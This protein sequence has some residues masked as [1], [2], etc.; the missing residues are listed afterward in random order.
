M[1]FYFK[2]PDYTP[3][4]KERIRRL[5]VLREEMRK[6]AGYL[7]KLKAYY[8]DHIAQFLNDWGVTIDVRLVSEGRDPLMPFL[9]FPKQVELVDWI[10]ERW[11]N[12]EPGVVVKARDVGA[13]W[14]AMAAGA[15]MCLFNRNFAVGVG[16]ATEIKL[17]RSGDP[18]T[19]FYKL[20]QFLQHLPPE[21]RG[22]WTLDK[23]SAYMRLS[24][25]ETGSSI[26]GEAGD[27]CGR[28]GRKSIFFVDESA[29]FEHPKLIDA[30]LAATTNCRIDMSS[31]NG[32][33]NSFY[34]KA[35]N[36]A[37][38][39]FDFTWRDDPRK[40]QAWYDKKCAELDP[41]IVAQEINCDWN[42]SIE[43][44]VIPSAWVQ[45]AVGLHERLG[46]TVAGSKRAALDVADR[47]VDKNAMAFTHGVLLV[48]AESWSGKD[49]DIA[50][51]TSKAFRLCDE[52]GYDEFDYDADG[53][54]AGVRGDARVLNEHR[55]QP[56]PDARPRGRPINVGEYRGSGAVIFPERIVPRTNRKNEDFYSNRKA[57][58]WWSAKLRFAESF[59]ASK[60]EPY[61]PDSIIC[62]AR[63]IPELSRLTS[64][65]SQA[66]V[67]ETMT[68]KLQIN[69]TPDDAMS[70]NL[71]DAI[72]MAFAPRKPTMRVSDAALDRF[73]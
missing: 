6:D 22:G 64:E 27:Q 72:I 40:D 36:P 68:G 5:G 28:G 24:F 9:L 73:R 20:R 21:F 51:T 49:S 48:H 41:V 56:G 63:D 61:D 29:H 32:S 43:G 50:A 2:N 46:I 35:H 17:D 34:E 58:A 59:K 62:I 30:S 10:V 18:D 65:L 25:P 37:I 33:A 3:V 54:G 16:S 26:T 8:R 45:A 70:P 1:S 7:P 39:R 57:Q 19:L 53:L 69:K 31:V 4:L 52:R 15:S 14:V 38:K 67:K 60:G 23:N 47:G 12:N 42:A 11:K 71:A 66:T 13:S 44:V 55:T